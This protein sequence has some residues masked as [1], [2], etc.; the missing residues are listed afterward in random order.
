[1]KTFLCMMMIG[2]IFSTVHPIENAIYNQAPM[3]LR[4]TLSVQDVQDA[5]NSM[6]FLKLPELEPFIFDDII[7]AEEETAKCV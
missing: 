2:S 6:D 4:P 7:G 5:I 3:F 1:M